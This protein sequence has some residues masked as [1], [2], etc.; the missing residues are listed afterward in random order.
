M[1]LTWFWTRDA[2]QAGVA[3]ERDPF[4]T[5][6]HVRDARALLGLRPP[7]PL[8]IFSLRVRPHRWTMTTN[9]LVEAVH[10]A[11][12]AIGVKRLA[13][14]DRRERFARDVVLVALSVR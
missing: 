8:E 2:W 3:S 5:R 9:E 14:L 10:K 13:A 11:M 12:N 7:P 6:S 1:R 4:S